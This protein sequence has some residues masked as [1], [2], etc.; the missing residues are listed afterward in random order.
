MQ[1]R[2]HKYTQ[3]QVPI[4]HIAHP[5]THSTAKIMSQKEKKKRERCAH[6]DGFLM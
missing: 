1:P 5:C 3:N 2:A 6:F 4:E